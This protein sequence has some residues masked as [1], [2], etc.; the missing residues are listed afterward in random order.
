MDRRVSRRSGYGRPLFDHHIRR[1]PAGIHA[2]PHE[3]RL[4]LGGGTHARVLR[5]ALPRRLRAVREKAP[6]RQGGDLQARRGA[7]DAE[8]AGHVL[9]P[10][11][12][13]FFRHPGALLGHHHANAVLERANNACHEP[14]DMVLLHRGAGRVRA[15]GGPDHTAGDPPASRAAEERLRSRGRARIWG[16]GTCCSLSSAPC[17]SC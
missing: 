1:H 16:S 13:R 8:A 14:A 17:S 10:G 2:L 4:R 3:L 9:V 6:A 15:S 12:C 7:E 5:H 11:L